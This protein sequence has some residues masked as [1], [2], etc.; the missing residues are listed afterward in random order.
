MNF[1][2]YSEN[3]TMVE[4]CLLDADGGEI[5]HPIFSHTGFVWHIYVP[6]I[7]PGQRYGYRV[8]GP[9]EPSRGLRFNPNVL[10][11]D[12]YAKA[13][14]GV[15]RWEA[16]GFAYKLGHPD[17]DFAMAEGDLRGAPLGVVVDTSFDWEGDTL[18]KIPLHRSVFYE[19]HVRGL[20][21]LHP[22]VP[23]HL[24]GTYAGMAHPA[25]V[26][27]L[28]ELGVTAVELMPVHAFVDDKSLVDR[29]LRNYWGYSTI[30]F[31]APDVRYK[32]EGAPLASEVREF[33]Q[34]VKVFHRAGIE[35]ILDVVYNHT[36]EGNHLGPTMAFKGIDNPTYYRLV[37]GDARH[38][39]DYTGTGN[40]LNVRHPQVL[41][42]IMDSLRYW[43][44]EMHVDG[45][46]FDLASALARN[47][48]DVDK[49]SSFFTLIH[50]SPDLRDVKI[51]AEPWDVGDGGYQ[52][53]NF[54]V[55]WAEWNGR[56]RDTIRQLWA[57][58]RNAGEVGYRLTGSSDLYESS[59]RRPPASINLITAHDGFTLSDLVTYEKKHNEANG[60]DNRDGNDDEHA[61]NGGIEGPTDDAVVNAFRHRQRRNLLATL[62]LSQGTPLLVAGDEMGRTQ[63]GNN[64][65]YC[66]DNETSWVDWNLD[67]E[68]RALLELTKR[69]LRIRREHPALH[70][71]KFFQGRAI[72]GTSLTD[73]MWHNPDGR[74]WENA[75]DATSAA[76]AMF[77]AGRGID[78]TDERGRPIVDDDFLVV[79][80]A[81][82]SDVD[83]LVPVPGAPGES[84]TALVDT[85]DDHTEESVP[86][87][88][89]TRLTAKSLKF[90]RAP[91]RV[92]RTGGARHTLGS[93]YRLQLN[94]RF[95]FAR[96]TAIV[97]YLA[98]LGITDVYVSPIMTAT[99]GSTHGYDV[100]DHEKVNPELGGEEGLAHFSDALR[101]RKMGLVVDWVPNHMGI[102]GGQNLAWDD[103]LE[104]GPSSVHAEA[105]DIDWHPPKAALADRVLLPILQESY[106]DAL[107]KGHLR[108]VWSEQR[109]RL[110]Y[111]T[112]K[113]PL[114]PRT[115]RPL[116]EN[117]LRKSALPDSDPSAQELGSILFS[118][119]GMPAASD[120]EPEDRRERAREKE[121]VK[122]RLAAL[123]QASPEIREAID[124]ALVELNGRPDDPRS[125]D[126]LDDLLQRQSYRLAWWR[127]AA[128]EINYRRFFDVND[129]AALRMEHEPI[130]DRAHAA[131]SRLYK[132]GR[133]EAL[134]LDHTDGLFDPSAYFEALQRAFTPLGADVLRENP[135]DRAR[136]LPILVEK[137]LGRGE[138]MPTSWAVDGTTGYELAV[139]VGGLWVDPGAEETF[140]SLYRRFTG[141]Q[142]TFAEHV[143]ESKKHVLAFSLSSELNMLARTLEGIAGRNRRWRD[144]TLI[145][146]TRAL[147]ETMAAFGVYRTYLRPSG[148]PTAE[149]ERHVD[150]AIAIA[151][152]RAPTIS[153]EVFR[154]LRA[155]LLGRVDVPE[156][157]RYAIERFALR[158]QQAT[159]PVMAKAV[160]DTAY[161]R[162]VRLVSLN[163]VGGSP[164]VFGRS[165]DEFHEQSMLRARGWPLSMTTLST[166][167]TKRGEDAAARISALTELPDMF[168]RSIS[169]LRERTR[170]LRV[171][172]DGKRAPSPTL[173]YLFW[174]A[175]VGAIPFG[176]D[177]TAYEPDLVERM[178][179]YLMKAAKEAKQETHWTNPNKAFDDT[180]APFVKGALEDPTVR[181][182]LRE[183]T[184]AVDPIAVQSALAQTVLK[185]TAP[186]IP[187]TYQGS[188]LWNQALV[189]PDN[190]RE[191]DFDLRRSALADLKARLRDETDRRTLVAELLANAPNGRVKL[192]TAHVLLELRR[193]QREL[194]LRGNYEARA[195]GQHVVAFSRAFGGV[196]LLVAVPRLCAGRGSPYAL[197]ESAWGTATLRPGHRGTYTNV[198][199]GAT[200]EIG[201]EVPLATLFQDF[202]AAV[203]LR[204]ARLAS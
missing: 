202:P 198:L 160:E 17:E 174:Q 35:V 64:N 177:G 7:E 61:A 18:P 41:T 96:A 135:D 32:Q 56:Y 34:M 149:D 179:G 114:G 159:A 117:V 19:A 8:Y 155:V 163:E 97:P 3:A 12:P 161:Y 175:M 201:D 118:L 4:L 69:L 189:D 95:G 45:F 15:E 21:K 67:D 148:R 119:R 37:E 72:Y 2:L 1:T 133:F 92:V 191:V 146:L 136:P 9:Y 53:G 127:V 46:R 82:D 98:E 11:L 138:S 204:H 172:V 190:R 16:G 170:D 104:S 168:G 183:L 141:D 109:F 93:T 84:W 188:E 166:H 30:G 193:N 126:A 10:L 75:E 107:E 70:R 164:E 74:R 131:L 85:S 31:F 66:Q 24:R 57:H 145:T 147:R 78:D 44:G 123:V 197:G 94:P 120:L 121:V 51:V 76:F 102:Q 49:L 167:D 90:F 14:D 110:V 26:R 39:F 105:F 203:L 158:V 68:K 112:R 55:R 108:V 40:T 100:I 99:E 182:I 58:G 42:L 48:H 192:Y 184:A 115:L 113:L 106:G 169:R 187:D 178:T 29:G 142:K 124:V 154:F 165:I 153:A 47:L 199:T 60:E 59:G 52:V 122:R 83:F 91:S 140:T 130:F 181:V 80:N 171:T 81:T 73:I 195:C 132:E 38:Y 116:L 23:E 101:A 156:D 71:A 186:G 13:V 176:W 88:G 77:L 185:L 134:R 89:T 128:E 22:E 103:V 54:P 50:Q 87:G 125:F 20:T 86:L 62:L 63:R 111:G 28:K 150:E 143:L 43:A 139:A 144:F 196:R 151:E 157:E 33:K 152:K 36:A 129:L 137:I 5:R 65:A 27:H 200:L 194:F 6:R 180:I 79:V 173:E 162:Y 25:V